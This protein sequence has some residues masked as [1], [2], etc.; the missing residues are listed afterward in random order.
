MIE[1]TLHNLEGKLPSLGAGNKTD[2]RKGRVYG[3]CDARDWRQSLWRPIFKG[4]GT[5]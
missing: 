5:P 3:T 1:S 4:E 2:R